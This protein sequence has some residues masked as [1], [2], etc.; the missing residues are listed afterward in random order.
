MF[1]SV[2]V[3]ESMAR[4]IQWIGTGQDGNVH[5]VD[6]YVKG[7]CIHRFDFSSAEQ[8]DNLVKNIAR[9]LQELQMQ[10]EEERKPAE[11]NDTINR[12]IETIDSLRRKWMEKN[13]Q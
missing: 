11:S 1:E 9:T 10:R 3:S 7:D 13:E 5:W 4:K 12:L 8:R 6:V 2:L